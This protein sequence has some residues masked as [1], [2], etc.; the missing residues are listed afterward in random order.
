MRKFLRFATLVVIIAFVSH[1]E[2]RNN[3]RQPAAQRGALGSVADPNFFRPSFSLS[4]SAADIWLGGAGNWSNAGFWSGGLPGQNS[5]VTINTG[6]DYVTLDT[7][8]TINSLTLGGTN[9][10]STLIDSTNGGYVI[11]IAG[12]LTVNQ[13]GTLSLSFDDGI[14]AGDSSNAGTIDLQAGSLYVGNFTNSGVI[15]FQQNGDALSYLTANAVTNSGSISGNDYQS[16]VLSFATLNNTS[17]GWISSV[18]LSVSGSMTNSGGLTDSPFS[19]GGLLT[20]TATGGIQVYW[21]GGAGSLNNSGSIDIIY[22]SLDVAGDALNSGQIIVIDQGDQIGASLAVSGNLTNTSSGSI[23]VGGIGFPNSWSTVYVGANLIN[24]GTIQLE[25]VAQ[26]YVNGTVT[27]SGTITTTNSSGVQNNVISVGGRFTN[28]AGATLQLLG[29]GDTATFG[30]MANSGTVLVGNAATLNIPVGARSGANT[31]AGFVNSGN[32]FIQQG[33]TLTSYTAYNQTTG[34]TTVDGHLGGIINFA[35]GSVYGNGG[36][37]SGSITSNAS[38]NF[39]DAPMTVGQ[40]TFAGNFTQGI[41]GNLTFDIA[42][43]NQYDQMNVSGQAHL[44]GTM[45]VDLLHGY[46]P[47]VGNDFEIMTFASESGT[48][49]NVVGL[50]IDNQEHFILQY[51]SNNLTLDVVAGQLDGVTSVKLGSG[52]TISYE[53]FIPTAEVGSDGELSMNE[54]PSQTTPEPSAILMLSTGFVVMG[55]ML[56]KRGRILP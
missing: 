5:D 6:N 47:Q 41:R 27:N 38:I 26:A 36:T 30:S 56:R 7:S 28:S 50:P 43:L 1:A 17:S 49:S 19:V 3:K 24:S 13:S 34:Q 40:M 42:S 8:A 48:F 32:V 20:N 45:T 55:G 21:G 12:A 16:P 23:A 9:G 11:S 18:R 25:G 33:G 29:A 22:N 15:N 10:S 53:P 31:R 14:S 35:G 52:S 44:N 4:P 46:I 2:A 39:G 54:T 37:I 51:N